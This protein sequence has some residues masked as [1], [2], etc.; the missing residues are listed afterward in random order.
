M[1][2]AEIRNESSVP[3]VVSVNGSQLYRLMID[4]NATGYASP[5]VNTRLKRIEISSQD[6][7]SDARV[8]DFNT[9]S[10]TI[11]VIVVKGPPLSVEVVHR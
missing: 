3:L 1:A 7:P 6:D 2:N 11:V 4:P 5:G 9:F 8:L 10:D